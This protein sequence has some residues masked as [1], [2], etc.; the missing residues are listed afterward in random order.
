MP[1][2]LVRAVKFILH[3]FGE[4]FD[5]VNGEG[6]N[7]D[8]NVRFPKE[9]KEAKDDVVKLLN[10]IIATKQKFK[11]KEIV[12]TLIGKVS[13]LIKAHRIDE[14]DFLESGR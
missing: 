8:D 13:A 3:Y 11:A 12:N 9:K 4:E 10:V 7:M 1:K 14:Q 6:A 5:E 2:R